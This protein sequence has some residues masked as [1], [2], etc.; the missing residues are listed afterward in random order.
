M[1]VLALIIAITSCQK[2]T[3][4]ALG[5]YPKDPPAPPYNPLKSFWAFENNVTDEGEDKLTG[6]PANLTYV[7]GITGQ[8]ILV[9]AGGYLLL[10]LKDTL[11]DPNE[12]VSIPGD[13][14]AKLGS[15]TLAFW[16]NGKG[17]AAGGPINDGAQGLF[18][19]SN[20]DQFWGN[21]EIFLENYTD[22]TDANAAWI[23]IHMFNGTAEEWTADDNTK[24]KNVLNKWTHIALT[25]DAAT[26]MLSLYKDGAPT[27]VSNKVLG[28]GTYGKLKYDGVTG[29]VLG[30]FAFQTDPTL[31]NHG[32]EGWAKSFNGALDQ[33]RI[34]NK[35]LSSA[36]VLA[37]YD[38]KL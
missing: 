14:L 29:M 38:S 16:M 33:F 12:F 20:K 34:Y 28:G 1:L 18:A 21:L 10:P 25:Y 13:T 7:A 23:K 15:F 8:A 17:A 6:V 31:T 35:A 24:L 37:L 2:L 9:G 30:S 27:A 19:I 5:D 11:K 26:S 32:P 22:T 4:P 36:E 3:R